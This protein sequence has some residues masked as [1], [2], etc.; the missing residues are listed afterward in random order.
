[1]KVRG[2]RDRIYGFSLLADSQ[3]YR[4]YALTE[5]IICAIAYVFC[6]SCISPQPCGELAKECIYGFSKVTLKSHFFPETI[7]RY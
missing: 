7:L 6:W 1:M 3:N 5:G 2:R 4:T